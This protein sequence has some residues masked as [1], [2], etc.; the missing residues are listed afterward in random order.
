MSV[1]T[2]VSCVSQNTNVHV[3]PELGGSGALEQASRPL[4]PEWTPT[5]YRDS[6]I[7]TEMLAMFDNV[8]DGEV[9]E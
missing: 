7:N 9:V 5:F 6:E 4:G 1:V 2:S 8:G 3:K